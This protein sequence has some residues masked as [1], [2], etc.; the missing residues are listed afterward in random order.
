MR[1]FLDEAYSYMPLIW[2]RV[3]RI[4]EFNELEKLIERKNIAKEK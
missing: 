1:K 4:F 2:K 3:P